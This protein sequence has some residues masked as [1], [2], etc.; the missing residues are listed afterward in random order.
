[1]RQSRPIIPEQKCSK[2]G[3]GWRS[4]ITFD[5]QE[6]GVD[7]TSAV[8]GSLKE[9]PGWAIITRRVS[10]ATMTGRASDSLEDVAISTRRHG[11][12]LQMS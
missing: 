12:G 4:I 2:I 3:A 11:M 6:R 8:T 5:G 7:I 1:M 10:F 9:S